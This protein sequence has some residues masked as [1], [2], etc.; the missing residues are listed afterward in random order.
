M[1]Y[2][3]AFKSAHAAFTFDI[4]RPGQYSTLVL[5]NELSEM[6]ENV[7][8]FLDFRVAVVIRTLQDELIM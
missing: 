8:I 7:K 1:S 4:L 3:I 5:A 6:R 2:L